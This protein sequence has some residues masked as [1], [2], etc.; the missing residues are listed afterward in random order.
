M[1]AANTCITKTEK[2]VLSGHIIIQFSAYINRAISG[3]K[4]DQVL[5][6]H[7]IEKNYV[8]E[9]QHNIWILSHDQNYSKFTFM[10]RIGYFPE[11]RIYLV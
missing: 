3:E 5:S 11:A 8:K 1:Y 10:F 6:N 4:R 2:N 9:S 7:K